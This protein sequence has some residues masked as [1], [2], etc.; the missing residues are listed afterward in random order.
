MNFRALSLSLGIF[1]LAGFVLVASQDTKAP[2]QAR[3]FKGNLHTHSLWS[4]GDDF[5]E[6]IADWYKTKGYDFLALTEHNT[7]A[8][9][10][11]WIDASKDA[12]R[13]LAVKKCVDRFGEA[14][15][16]RK[17]EKG[18]DQ[19]RLKTLAEVKTKVEEKD[20]F[21]MISGEEITH[22]YQKLPIHM[23]AINLKEVIKPVDGVGVTETIQVNQRL[24][25]EKRRKSGETIVSFLNH[26]NFG[27]GV[28]PEEIIPAD[29]LRYYEV[30]NGHP[31]TNQN[32]D[33]KHPSVDRIWDL[34]LASRLKANRAVP[35]LGVATDDSHNYHKEGMKLATPGRGWIMVRARELDTR[36]IMDAIDAGDFYASSGVTLADLKTTGGALSLKIQGDPGITYKTTFVATLK[37]AAE[38]AIGVVVGEAEGLEASYKL[39][40]KELYVRA[41]V[42]SS[43][44][45]PNPSFKDETC[46]AWT[47]PVLP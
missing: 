21:L 10:T 29:E 41:R 26:P 43:K 40:G 36:Q 4:D 1:T 46:A 5:P 27:W 28:K 30:Y 45:H 42:T 6:M 31:G 12:T 25:A 44:A 34:V 35:L 11:R 7:M 15:V 17:E 24:V 16:D 18:K 14:W 13:K 32:G 23:N 47:Q 22:S 39:T 37:D 8:N 38:D 3:F 9:T 19:I 33:A 20:K 2:P